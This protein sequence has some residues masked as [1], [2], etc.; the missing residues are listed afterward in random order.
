[1]IRWVYLTYFAQMLFIIA[2]DFLLYDKI[3]AY[4]ACKPS[5]DAPVRYAC[6]RLVPNV[7]FHK[8]HA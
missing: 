3:N 8:M 7:R 1:M 6:V 5:I 2:V 4:I